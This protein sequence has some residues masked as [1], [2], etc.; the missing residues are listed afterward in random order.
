MSR[1]VLSVARLVV[2]AAAIVSISYQ[3]A[4]LRSEVPVEG[5]TMHA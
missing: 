2:A 3:F 1:I 5:A 4:T